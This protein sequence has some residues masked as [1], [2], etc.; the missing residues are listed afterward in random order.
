LDQLL[1]LTAPPALKKWEEFVEGCFSRR[2][3][4]EED[5]KANP[6]PESE[7]QRDFF[8]Y[9]FRAVDP[10]TGKLGYS[11]DELYGESESLIIAGS[12]TTAITTAAALFYLGRNPEI[13]DAIAEEILA[14][15]PTADDIKGG[16][17][18][19]GCRNLQAFI[20]ETLRMSPPVPADLSREVT[21][22]GLVVDGR[23]FAP[24]TRVSTACYCL[25]HNKDLY[26]EPFRFNPSRW[27]VDENDTTGASAE[28]VARAESGY[29]PFSAG[30]RGCVGKNLAYLELG[31][32]LA[33]VLHHFE[34]RQ[35]PSNNLGGGSPEA[36]EGRREPDQYQ[37]QDI[38]VAIRDGPMVQL[39]RRQR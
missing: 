11:L 37:L 33:K 12:D 5:L 35:D 39:R 28:M 29:M 8:H 15:F 9:L 36:R 2:A 10:E 32:V 4:V 16:P 23:Y 7:I 18:L 24:G 20:K 25:H 26:D 27:I 31:I 14:A 22:G 21:D 3:K 19:H 30:P 38:F 1:A 34:V 13:Q 17:T 6:K